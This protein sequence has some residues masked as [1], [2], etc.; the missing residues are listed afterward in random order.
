MIRKLAYFGDPILRAKALPIQ[1][2]TPEIKE[3]VADMIETLNASNGIGLAAPQVKESCR[4]FITAVPKELEDGTV[5]P[6]ILRIFINPKI[7]FLSEETWIYNEGCLSI[8]KV[9]GDVERPLSIEVE[10]TDLNG[11][12]FKGSFTGLEA[13]CILHENDHI[14]GVLFIDRLDPKER[15]KLEKSLRNVKNRFKEV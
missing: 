5:I 2:I 7:T 14:N 12:L 1:G 6:P 3:L 9:Y 15:K 8:P 13:R 11:H 4:L 10:A